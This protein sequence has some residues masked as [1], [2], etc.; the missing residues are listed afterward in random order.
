MFAYQSKDGAG[1][2]DSNDGFHGLGYTSPPRSKNYVH[3]YDDDDD[4]DEA[5]RNGYGHRRVDFRTMSGPRHELE[6]TIDE[7]LYRYSTSHSPQSSPTMP[8]TEA[9]AVRAGI[10]AGYSLKHWDPMEL[11][12]ILLGSVFDANS[13]GKWIYDWTVVH[14]GASTPMADMAGE[15]WLL[16]IKLAGKMKKAEECVGRSSTLKGLEDVESFLEGGHVLWNKFKNLIRV[17][18]R[19][20]LKSIKRHGAGKMGKDGAMEFVNTLF[21]RDRLLESTERIMSQIRLWT[22]RF[23]MNCEKTIK[24]QR[25]RK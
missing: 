12:V 14:F 16:L 3:I 6:D 10:P 5:R 18:E 19:P 17:C 9:D 23:D 4:D 7:Q 20:M 11:P 25:R 21:G 22:N 8:A 1:D 13:L 2:P 24:Y 15:L